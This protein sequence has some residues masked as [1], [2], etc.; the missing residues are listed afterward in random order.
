MS[1]KFDTK[2]LPLVLPEQQPADLLEQ[3]AG[4]AQ[5]EGLARL[6]QR[7]IAA[8]KIPMQTR[9]NSDLS[10]GGVSD[11]TNRGNFDRL[12][13][14]ELA[15]DD[16]SLMARLA[17]NEA[18]YLRR[19]ELPTHHVRQRFI[20]VDTSIK[21]WGT[22][23]IFAIATALACRMNNKEKASVSTFA[24]QGNTYSEMELLTKPDIIGALAEL[25]PALHSAGALTAFAK[26]HPLGREQEY[27]LITDEQ[28]FY[29][30]AF[31]AAF[32][33]LRTA[34]GFLITVSRSGQ[35]QLF[36]YKAGNRRLLHNISL[37]LPE[38]LSK[39]K[40]IIKTRKEEAYDRKDLPVFFQQTPSPLY[41]PSSKILPDKEHMFSAFGVIGITQDQRLLYWPE[42]TKGAIELMSFIPPG[43]YYFGQDEKSL[44]YIL[45]HIPSSPQ[46]LRLYNI[47]TKTLTMTTTDCLPKIQL[48]DPHTIVF[49]QEQFIIDTSNTRFTVNANHGRIYSKSGEGTDSPLPSDYEFHPKDI[50]QHINNGYSVLTNIEQIYI[51]GEYLM[52]DS[53]SLVINDNSVGISL[54]RPLHNYIRERISAIS[55]NPTQINIPDVNYKLLKFTWENGCEAFLDSRGL[56]HLR[57][58]NLPEVTIVLILNRSIA[59]C[60]SDG[61]TCG[62]EY[63]TG[64]SPEKK[65]P[66]Q[67]FYEKYIQSFIEALK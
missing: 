12:L 26:E 17:N 8:L 2:Q 62:T 40:K 45:H 29:T 9:S 35:L 7:L 15:H 21:M 16:L 13:L 4:D 39:T 61:A 36:K 32:A 19:E 37:D 53:R 1:S 11:I 33:H 3:L 54:K 34:H 67:E 10:F 52:L 31:Q 38:L 65:M 47:H 20:L 63:F 27:F 28:L 64:K 50:K 66:V 30:P 42:K 43:K 22:P 48:R 41:F 55:E 5:T 44:I 24:L 59:C 58:P 18:L 46:I 14:S 25:S 56:L 51:D 49:H 60:A 6:T 57:A 23:R